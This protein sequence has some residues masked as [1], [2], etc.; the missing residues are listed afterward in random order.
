MDTVE[1]VAGTGVFLLGSCL[2]GD[3]DTVGLLRGDL[4]T[5]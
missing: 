2:K 1:V 4:S 5:V 3:T